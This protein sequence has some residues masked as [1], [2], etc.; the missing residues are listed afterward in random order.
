MRIVYIMRGVPGSGKSTHARELAGTKG[1]IHST[2]TY[3]V[4]NGEYRFDP[5]KLSDN[6][7]RNLEAFRE[8]LRQG[9]SI[10]ICDNTNVLHEHYEPYIAAAVEFGY[11]VEIRLMPHPKPKVAAERNVHGVEEQV[12]QRMLDR[13]ED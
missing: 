11:L 9:V 6:H 8:S 2:D 13:W 12:I 5:T 1:A 7:R 10:V 3:F 4:V